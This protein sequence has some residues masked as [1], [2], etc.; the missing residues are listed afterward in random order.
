MNRICQFE[1]ISATKIKCSVC[2]TERD[3]EGP[4]D[5]YV[6]HCGQPQSIPARF[7]VSDAHPLTDPCV[8][9]GPVLRQAT[10]DVCGQRGKP[11]DVHAC[12][13]HGECQLRRYQTRN[14]PKWCGNCESYQPKAAATL[15]N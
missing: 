13:I 3:H 6:R 5:K 7:D 11:Y 2:G 15:S 14:G 1:R 9:F 8:H 4:A 10:C 12:A